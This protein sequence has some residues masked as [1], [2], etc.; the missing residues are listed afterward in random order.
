MKWLRAA[1]GLVLLAALALVA[2]HAYCTLSTFP[3]RVAC[4]ASAISAAYHDVDSV[5]SFGCVGPW[6]YLWATVGKEEGEIGV[7]EVVHYDLAASSWHNASRLE[8][9]TKDRL[10]SYVQY[11]G[12]NSN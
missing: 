10:P 6:A 8:Y 12:C 5:Q 2:N 11:W 9:C 7:T 3:A 4:N 1:G